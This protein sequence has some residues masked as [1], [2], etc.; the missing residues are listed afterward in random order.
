MKITDEIIKKVSDFVLSAEFPKVELGKTVR[1]PFP[2]PE[3]LRNLSG[4]DR[5][6][7]AT[8]SAKTVIRIAFIV[9]VFGITVGKFTDL[10]QSKARDLILKHIEKHG[11]KK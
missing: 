4:I 9:D 11:G 8:A 1:S 6:T 3:D 5:I 7:L 2:L 10:W